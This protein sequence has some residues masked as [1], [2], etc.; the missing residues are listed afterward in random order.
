M[1]VTLVKRKFILSILKH[2]RSVLPLSNKYPG[3]QCYVGKVK[4]RKLRR[5]INVQ[6]ND[7]VFRKNQIGTRLARLLATRGHKTLTISRASR[8]IRLKEGSANRATT[9]YVIVNLTYS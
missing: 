3:M 2:T 7:E 5:E 4:L 8:L 9:N 6:C 1:F